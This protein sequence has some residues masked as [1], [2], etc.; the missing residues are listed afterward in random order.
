MP[1]PPCGGEQT[2]LVWCCLGI[3]FTLIDRYLLRRPVSLDDSTVSAIRIDGQ[4]TAVPTIYFLP[5]N[6]PYWLAKRLGLIRGPFTACY[7]TAPALVSSEPVRSVLALKKIVADAEALLESLKITGTSVRIVGY[8]LGSYPATYLANRLQARLYSIAPADRGDL[9][10]W[11]S[12]AARKIRERARAKGYRLEDYVEAMAGYNPVEN[13]VGLA[14]SSTFVV[15]DCDPFVPAE[16]S[17]ALVEAV[18]RN[19]STAKILKTTGGHV[20]TLLVGAWF[21]RRAFRK[22]RLD[23]NAAFRLINAY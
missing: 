17:L 14:P 1:S 10:I 13:L 3:M 5:W 23:A 18:K 6:T 12:P 20:R 16:R 22:S 4:K 11:Q 7:E 9:M 8:S 21:L 15:G 19:C 2:T